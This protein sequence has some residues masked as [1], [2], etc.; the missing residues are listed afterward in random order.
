VPLPAAE[1]TV[2]PRWNSIAAASLGLTTLLLAC[3]GDSV[4]P[5]SHV[6]A[7]GRYAYSLNHT[8]PEAN[9][10]TGT[11]VIT[12]ASADSIGARWEVSQYEAAPYLGNWN[13]GAYILYAMPAGNPQS[14]TAA[15]SHR[16]N[17][18]G[19]ATELTCTAGYNAF[20]DGVSR[21]YDATCTLSFQAP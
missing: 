5:S 17:R 9:P 7:L 10:I 12:Y 8:G 19:A 11:L 15:A 16:I 1:H 3:S 13:S 4:G 14:G 21:T 20:S 2:R 6:P 18:A